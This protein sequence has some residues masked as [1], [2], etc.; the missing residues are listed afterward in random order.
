MSFDLK[1][2]PKEQHGLSGTPTYRTWMSMRQRCH[3]PKH[4][5][6]DRYGGRGIVVCERWLDSVSAFVEDMG[7]RP[8][9]KTIDRI[10]NDGSYTPENCRWATAQQQAENKRKRNAASVPRPRKF[11][12]DFTELEYKRAME[13]A[14]DYGMDLGRFIRAVVEQ[15]SRKRPILTEYLSPKSAKIQPQPEVAR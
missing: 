4:P 7:E 13:I 11:T 9:G 8:K 6:Y 5:E 1:R 14:N 3:D 10:D 12:V 2:K 15:Y